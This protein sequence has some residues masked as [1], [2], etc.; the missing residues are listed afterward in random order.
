M[1]LDIIPAS[2]NIALIDK[3]V[4]TKYPDQEDSGY[5]LD[6]LVDRRSVRIHFKASSAKSA[7]L[8]KTPRVADLQP[9]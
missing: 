4:S 7:Y 5:L 1:Y 3:L 8:K 9:Q 2:H 6:P